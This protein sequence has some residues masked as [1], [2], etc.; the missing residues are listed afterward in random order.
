VKVAWREILMRLA[1]VCSWIRACLLFLVVFQRK[2]QQLF[3]ALYLVVSL[4]FV[5]VLWSI[6]ATVCSLAER[7][8]TEGTV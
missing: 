5:A 6:F 7:H 1:L 3:M 4:G 8:G 2:K